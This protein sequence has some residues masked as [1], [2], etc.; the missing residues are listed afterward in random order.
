VKIILL[1]HSSPPVT[2]WHKAAQWRSLQLKNA[3]LEP[4][5]RDLPSEVEYLGPQ[6]TVL[7]P[8]EMVS[9]AT[10][11]RAFPDR[12][13]EVD[14]KYKDPQDIDSSQGGIPLPSFI[15]QR[16]FRLKHLLGYSSSETPQE[17]KRRVV[18]TTAR[19]IELAKKDGASVLVGEGLLLRLVLLKLKSIGFHGPI[20]PRLKPGR[21]I[22]LSY[23]T[24]EETESTVQNG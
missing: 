15:W 22:S 7:S 4:D 8:P 12:R 11:R 23:D 9:V 5:L 13:I 17:L 20:W 19:L 1:R 10:S 24:L 6:G 16:W 2:G 18:E 3:K 14:P 21:A